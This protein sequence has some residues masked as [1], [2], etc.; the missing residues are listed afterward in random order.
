MLTV[1]QPQ[2]HARSPFTDILTWTEFFSTMEE[3]ITT[4][5]PGKAPQLFAYLRTIV[6]ASQTFEGLTWMAYDTQCRCRAAATKSWDWGTTDT[7]LYNE[8]FT[9]RAR[10]KALCKLCAS[11]SHVDQQCPLATPYFAGDYYGGQATSSNLS[12]SM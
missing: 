12:R 2:V 3:V 10:A 11:E 6:R 1:Q 4:K 7:S 9:G 8:C 5:D